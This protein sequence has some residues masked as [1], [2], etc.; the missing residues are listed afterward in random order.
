MNRRTLTELAL[1]IG[2]LLGAVGLV[3]QNDALGKPLT[4]AP[5]KARVENTSGP[6]S[7]RQIKL[8]G[9]GIVTLIVLVVVFRGKSWNDRYK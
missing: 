3:S 7:E 2:C 9:G 8:I 4:A 6:F 5:P 1:A